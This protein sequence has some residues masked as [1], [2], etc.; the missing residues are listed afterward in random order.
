MCKTFLQN[1]TLPVKELV[2]N[3]IYGGETVTW[4]KHNKVDIKLIPREFLDVKEE[5]TRSGKL[6]VEI[7]RDT[8]NFRQLAIDAK[9]E[10][11]FNLDGAA[12]SYLAQQCEKHILL[13]LYDSLKSLGYEVGALIHDGCHVKERGDQY[14]CGTIKNTDIIRMQESI[15]KNTGFNMTLQVK[16][17]IIPNE[18]DNAYI[19]RDQV[20]GALWILGLIDGTYVTDN[21]RIFL[22]LDDV[23]IEDPV[24]IK[25]S[26]TNIINDTQIFK[27]IINKNSKKLITQSRDMRPSEEIRKYVLNHPKQVDGF[28]E[29]LW[30]SNIGILC[31][32]NGWFDFNK[33][34]FSPYGTATDP[35][36]VLKIPRNFPVK[37]FNILQRVMRMHGSLS[38]F[39]P[40]NRDIEAIQLFKEFRELHEL[41]TR[42]IF[43]DD[44][45]LATT[46]YAFL[47]RAMA[48]K[49]IDKRWAVGIGQRDCGKGMLIKLLHLA[50]DK[51]PRIQSRSSSPRDGVVF[52]KDLAQMRHRA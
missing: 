19:M 41:I 34:E 52:E 36:T 5:I 29:R 2:F 6:L 37:K 35:E 8:C 48:G 32:K 15:S 17:F 43:N 30:K 1:R 10:N 45:Q 50:F 27:Y 3:C 22:K 7:Y 40:N 12:L 24:L 47:S 33:Q 51:Y 14:S 46:Y 11:Y 26:I 20:D 39:C 25:T 44:M 4:C 49:I 42:P 38:H 9:G 13:A 21:N 18:V 23:W 31:F 16:P 28:V